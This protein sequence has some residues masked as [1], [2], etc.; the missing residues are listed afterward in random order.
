MGQPS[1]FIAAFTNIIGTIPDRDPTTRRTIP[2]AVR[3]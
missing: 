1:S 3:T 2:D